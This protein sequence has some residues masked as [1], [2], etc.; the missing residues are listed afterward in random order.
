MFSD[1]FLSSGVTA[2][3]ERNQQGPL[4]TANPNHWT[5]NAKIQWQGGGHLY[6]ELIFQV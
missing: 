4:E 5:W 1:L 2:S 3:A 6:Y